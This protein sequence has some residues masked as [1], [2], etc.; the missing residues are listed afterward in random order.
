[1]ERLVT[2][3]ILASF[4]EYAAKGCVTPIEWSQFAVGHYADEKMEAARRD[5]VRILQKRPIPQED[6]DFLYSIASDLRGNI[7]E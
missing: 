7:P 4:I 5:C 1:M 3:S 2:R 6:L